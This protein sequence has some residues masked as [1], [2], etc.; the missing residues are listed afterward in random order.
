MN[1]LSKYETPQLSEM[2]NQ[3]EAVYIKPLTKR[4]REVL[5][6]II[7]GKTNWE[8]SVILSIGEESVKSHM[9]NIL[10]KL[11]AN[12]RTHAAAIALL[13]NLLFP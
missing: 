11:G 8:T 6:W 13:N 9:A 1:V 12:N 4:E 10:V 3:K 5:L 2:I 7:E